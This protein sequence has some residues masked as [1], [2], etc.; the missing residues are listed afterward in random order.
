M[1]NSDHLITL[2]FT[3][4]HATRLGSAIEATGL[5]V[6]AFVEGH[7]LCD[8]TYVLSIEC[9]SPEVFVIR[10]KLRH[11]L[12][13]S[14]IAHDQAYAPLYLLF[15]AWFLAGAN[16]KVEGPWADSFPGR[17][18]IVHQSVIPLQLRPLFQD[19]LPISE[20]TVY[21][22]PITTVSPALRVRTSI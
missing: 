11:P 7:V 19:G 1:C 15:V 13:D 5:F 18:G 17:G 20:R 9:V 10:A 4:N 21:P 2:Q 6:N 8:R 12:E 3:E 14:R 22:S 16:V